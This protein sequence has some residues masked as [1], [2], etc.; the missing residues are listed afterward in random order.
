MPEIEAL[1]VDIG[2]KFQ[3]GCRKHVGEPKRIHVIVAGIQETRDPFVSTVAQ[4]LAVLDSIPEL[5]WEGLG[6]DRM[7]RLAALDLCDADEGKIGDFHIPENE[8]VI[9]GG[10]LR[11]VGNVILHHIPDC[12]QLFVERNHRERFHLNG[13]LVRS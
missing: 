8:C 1:P 12:L 11:W 13:K 4:H 6:S 10:A 9:H 2:R 7:L 5:C 3:G